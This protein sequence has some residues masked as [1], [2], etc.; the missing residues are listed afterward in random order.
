MECAARTAAPARTTRRTRRR[1]TS[2]I[3]S[4]PSAYR[5]EQGSRK[6]VEHL[7][8]V[9]PGGIAVGVRLE[10]NAGDRVAELCWLADG[11]RQ[12]D[13]RL[14]PEGPPDRRPGPGTEQ[15]GDEPRDAGDRHSVAVPPG[16]RKHMAPLLPIDRQRHVTAAVVHVAERRAL[17]EAA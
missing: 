4:P 17:R 2:D 10:R 16:E 9:Q 11:P 8:G 6:L 3:P 7:G 14:A 5:N 13:S 12:H 1:C 15:P